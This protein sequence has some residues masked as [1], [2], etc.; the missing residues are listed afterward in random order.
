MIYIAHRGNIN[1]PNPSRENE[2][3]YVVEAL[4]KG[5]NAE[6]DVWF[7][8]KQWWL[9]HDKP[10]YQVEQ[11]FLMRK[12]LWC[13][14][15]NIEALEKMVEIPR[16]NCFW[17]QEDDAVLT[18]KKYLWT[19]PGKKLANNSIAVMPES[20]KEQ[21]MSMC[22][23]ICTDFITNYSRKTHTADKMIGGWFVGDFDPSVYKTKDFEV[24][25]K[26]H[27]K[28]EKWPKHFHKVA[29]EINYV[30]RGSINLNG[31]R[32]TAGQIYVVE[33]GEVVEINFL[34]RCEMI[35]VKVPSVKDDKF[36]VD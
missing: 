28:D 11:H 2:P 21:D 10:T 6:I 27:E 32:F 36:E 25:F 16:I 17:H 7:I 15:K 24:G 18:S 8:S 31:K 23:G 33:P 22:A 35:I 34:E 12:G 3:N 14:A 30:L 29:T 5:Y 20:A 26:V 19:F 9:G 13:H 4:D 1:G